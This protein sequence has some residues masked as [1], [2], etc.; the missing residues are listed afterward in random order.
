MPQEPT[1]VEALLASLK[2]ELAET[3]VASAEVKL[4]LAE[5]QAWKQKVDRSDGE[6]HAASGTRKRSC[7]RKDV[8]ISVITWNVMH[9]FG[10]TCCACGQ[11]IPHGRECSCGWRCHEI[12]KRIKSWVENGTDIIYLQE[13]S[14]HLLDELYEVCTAKGYTVISSIY[15]RELMGVA[16]LLSGRFRIQTM[17]RFRLQSSVRALEDHK[18][19]YKRSSFFFAEWCTYPGC[20]VVY[21]SGKRC[22]R[23]HDTDSF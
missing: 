18:A 15:H 6:V 21:E 1:G 13:V 3:R 8:T 2:A 22:L 12:V 5:L 19:F 23:V 9:W 11:L 20:P 14:Q 10:Y 4:G 7:E 17:Q 16:M